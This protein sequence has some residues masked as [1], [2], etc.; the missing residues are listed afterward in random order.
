MDDTIIK[1]QEAIS[2][3][4][5]DISHMSDVLYAQQKEIENLRQQVIKLAQKLESIRNDSADTQNIG[6]EPPPP[7]Y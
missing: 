5:E 2:H 7:H 4:G 1:L 6:A 3:Q